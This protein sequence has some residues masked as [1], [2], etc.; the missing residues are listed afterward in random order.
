M[1]GSSFSNFLRVLRDN[2][3]RIQSRFWPM[4]LISF[5]FVLFNIPFVL[6]ERL[7]YSGRI[8]K[9][10]VKAPVFI[11]GYP[12]SGTTFLMYLLSKDPQFGYS[13]MVECI[14]PHVMMTF[15]RLLQFIASFASP[16]KRPMDNLEL[17]PEVPIEEEFALGNMGMESMAHALYFPRRFSEYFDRFVLFRANPQEKKRFGENMH[18]L[19]QKL[20]VKK[21]GRRL[22]LKSP[23]NTGRIPVLLEL[24]PDA[25]FIFIHRHPY[26]VMQSNS[27][28]YES[29]LPLVS[30]QEIDGKL[31]S[32][33][34]SHTYLLTLQA[35]FRDRKLIRSG[36]LF[37]LKY[38]D[39][40]KDPVAM[41]EK[42]YRKLQLGKIEEALP[43]FAREAEKY[44]SYKVNEYRVD[45]KLKETI[46]R[47]FP[48]VYE[49]LGYEK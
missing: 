24:Y 11:L 32:E 49:K 45:V 2:N 42:I 34:V 36:N 10:E 8:K 9:A 48:E 19:F 22:L 14:G 47:K 13:R 4:L 7:I 44:R 33:H 43:F 25:K 30:F 3:F 41:L 21:N 15:G 37:E 26:Q 17:G 6:L 39:L 40:V 5:C 38:D 20:T 46:Y 16:K 18:F 31:M 23:F 29:I 35:Y 27:K 28:L 1:S 12:R